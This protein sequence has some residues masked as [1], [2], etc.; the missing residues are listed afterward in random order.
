MAG[1]IKDDAQFTLANLPLGVAARTGSDDKTGI[2]T[3]L[4][5]FV[6]FLSDLQ[7]ENILKGLSAEVEAAIAKVCWPSTWNW[8][9]C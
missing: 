9:P 2:V 8:H 1:N 4:R 5:G 3:R 7:R 6:Y